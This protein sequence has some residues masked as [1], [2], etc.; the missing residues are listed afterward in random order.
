MVYD[1]EILQELKEI[2]PFLLQVE[3]K[4]PYTISFSYFDQLSTII[5]SKIKTGDQVFPSLTSIN[6]YAAPAGYFD[7]LSNNI[8]RTINLETGKNEV[9][10]ELEEISPLLNTISKAPVY[11][12]P[13]NFF[14]ELVP[15]KSVAVEKRARVSYFTTSKKIISYAVAAV[16]IGLL[17]AGLFLFTGKQTNTTSV[18]NTKT[19]PEVNKLS[20]QEIVEFLKT[21]SP[22][23]GIVISNNQ[24]NKKDVDIKRMVDEMSDKEIQQFLEDNGE[25]NEM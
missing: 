16:V 21:T 3:N 18:A 11:S 10:K 6:P 20:E 9:F 19:L 4:S 8:I 25:K 13:V 17:V 12:I 24:S 2:C 14:S 23:E 15:N 22:A 5:L 1:S 7:N